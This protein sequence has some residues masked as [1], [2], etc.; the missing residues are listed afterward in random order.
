MM[1]KE[2]EKE[3]DEMK[4]KESFVTP[5][6]LQLREEME[7]AEEEER[8]QEGKAHMSAFIQVTRSHFQSQI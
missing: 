4:D 7:K 3:G 1:A 6:Y 8:K 5:A 2:R